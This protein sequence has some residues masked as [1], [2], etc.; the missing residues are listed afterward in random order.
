MAT[1]IVIFYIFTLLFHDFGKGII[2]LFLESDLIR[3]LFQDGGECIRLLFCTI[4]LNK[5]PVFKHG[6]GGGLQFGKSKGPKLVA[7]SP[8]R[9]GKT[10]FVPSPYQRVETQNS[11]CAPLQYG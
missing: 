11:L 7:P 8:S 1:R 2:L 10:P 5:G 6:Y 9:Q 3:L 4:K